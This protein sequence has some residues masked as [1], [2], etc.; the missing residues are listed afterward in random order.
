[1]GGTNGIE[2]KE[3]PMV[4]PGSQDQLE[5][6]FH[7]VKGIV[8]EVAGKLMNDPDVEADGETEE[9]AGKIQIKIRQVKKVLG[10]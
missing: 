9:I 1:M 4:K 6:K 2:I 7:D 8:K 10:K 5:G 3:R